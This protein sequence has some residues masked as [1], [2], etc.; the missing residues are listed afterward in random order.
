M[1]N[2]SAGAFN[3]SFLGSAG[4]AVK[5]NGVIPQ[6]KTGWAWCDGTTWYG[7]TSA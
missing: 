6:N 5:G 1:S 7:M 4:G 2:Q 3:V